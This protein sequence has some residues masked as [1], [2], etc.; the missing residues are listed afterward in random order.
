MNAQQVLRFKKDSMFVL[1]DFISNK[2]LDNKNLKDLNRNIKN[3]NKNYKINVNVKNEYI[4]NFNYVSKKS[5]IQKEVFPQINLSNLILSKILLFINDNDKFINDDCISELRNLVIYDNMEISL[6]NKIINNKLIDTIH[7]T[8]FKIEYLMD[9]IACENIQVECHIDRINSFLD[10]AIISYS[11]NKKL[12]HNHLTIRFKYSNFNILEE[13]SIT[14]LYNLE[15]VG[16]TFSF[17]P[18]RHKEFLTIERCN[19]LMNAYI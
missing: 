19:Y 9:C 13:A 7:N 6:E 17:D 5:N 11:N 2:T 1:T 10:F 15:Y 3:I 14:T 12:Y 4:K 8:D 18:L 16:D